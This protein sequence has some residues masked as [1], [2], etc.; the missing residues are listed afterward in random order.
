MKRVYTDS[1]CWK[2]PAHLAKNSKTELT[3]AFPA[4]FDGHTQRLRHDPDTGIHP[5]SHNSPAN[6]AGI[7]LVN[8]STVSEEMDLRLFPA[9]GFASLRN[10][11]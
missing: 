8:P 2:S 1:Q 9:S 7:S 11:G 5:C 4:P 6:T 10:M 3:I